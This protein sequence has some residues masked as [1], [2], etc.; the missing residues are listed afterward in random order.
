MLG[1]YVWAVLLVFLDP[2]A[3]NSTADGAG[4]GGQVTAAA[5]AD[6]AAGDPAGDATNHG[7]G[8]AVLIARWPGVAALAV[9]TDLIAVVHGA[10]DR[11]DRDHARIAG[12]G[13]GRTGRT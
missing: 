2:A 13:I 6:L 5:T 12:A 8:D 4:D 3:G 10:R 9:L 11:R 7:A 1:V